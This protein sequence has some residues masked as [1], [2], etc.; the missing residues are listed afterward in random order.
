MNRGVEICQSTCWTHLNKAIDNNNVGL[1]PQKLGGAALPSHLEKRIAN[2]AWNLFM[3]EVVQWVEEA[4]KETEYADY[5]TN[6]KPTTTW[7]KGWLKRMEFTTRVLRPLEQT[8]AEWNTAE[9]LEI[10]FDVA[11]DVLLDAGVVV[12]N[13]AYDPSVPYSEEIIITRPER[14]CSY[15]ETT[16]VELDCTKGGAGKRDRAIRIPFDDGETVV[17]KSDRCASAAC[18]RLGDGRAL[19]VYIVFGSGET[20]DPEWALD[21][22]TPDILDK[23]GEPLAWRYTC[24]TKGS[25]NEEFCADYVEHIL[26]PALGYPLPRDTH[27]GQQGVVVCDGVGSH[28]CFSVVEKAIELGME[29]LLRVPNLSYILQGEDTVNFKV[30]TIVV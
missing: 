18:G 15:D 11:R 10:Y 23:D 24:N 25:V 27:P 7:Y 13:H 2:V 29:I 22:K 3:E 1:S 4:I 8:R 19:P 16:R 26:R 21:I 30:S 6:G 17:T 28:L 5:F 9:N 20:Y 14:I 12:M